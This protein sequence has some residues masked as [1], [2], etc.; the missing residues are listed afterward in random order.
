ML[1]V[2]DIEPQTAIKNLQRAR[3]ALAGVDI[4]GNEV[5]PHQFSEGVISFA[6][7]EGMRR[8]HP[9]TLV[10]GLHAL[11]ETEITS[12]EKY[13]FLDRFKPLDKKIEEMF[14]RE[15]IN[16]DTA[17]NICISTGTSH[18]F[19][20]FFH[21]LSLDK[22]IVLT[23]PGYYHSLANW[24]NLNNGILD[25]VKTSPQNNYK[26]KKSDLLNWVINNNKKPKALVLF[27]PTY[28]GAL[29]SE[30]ELEE[31]SE[32]VEQ[33]DLQVIEDSL[34]MYTKYD[35]NNNIHH[36][37]NLDNVKENVVTIQGASKAYSLANM[38]IG[39]AC[40]ST[41]IIQKMNFYVGATQVDAPHIAKCMALQ[42]LEAPKLYL[43]ENVDELKLRANL[44]VSLI[45]E[46]NI[47]VDREFGDLIKGNILDI[48]YNPEAGHSILISFN[49]LRGLETEFGYTI[50]DSIDITRYF[51]TKCKV[52]L[53]PG[54]SMGF[55]DCTMR[56]SFGCVG[57]SHTYESSTEIE[58][59]LILR[60][61]LKINKI[62]K[63]DFKSLE[64][65]EIQ[66]EQ[67]LSD[68]SEKQ[69]K[70]FEKGRE[71]IEEGISTRLKLAIMSLI[72]FNFHTLAVSKE[73]NL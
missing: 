11:L 32:F 58:K 66:E 21:S 48:V 39:W 40:G 5:H 59:A 27:N 62:N 44:I 18:L 45:D 52:A 73:K 49:K 29:Y 57:L 41:E 72:L 28:T 31:I 2:K 71:F 68:Y 60:E 30:E 69:I 8:P 3:N 47:E 22:D 9:S 1:E 16:K 12:L 25:I 55:D 10:A 50:K 42:S 67:L 23:A 4:E 14:I 54:L 56:I 7:G 20:A 53:S 64:T 19:N 15:G 43:Q 6:D 46:I 61:A 33:Y 38:R 35:N 36:L 63:E 65:L 17:R 34:F 70:S 37:G 24:C 26:I 13:F 51:L